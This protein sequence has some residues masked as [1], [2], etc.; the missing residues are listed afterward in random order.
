MTYVSALAIGRA[1]RFDGIDCPTDDAPWIVAGMASPDAL[2]GNDRRRGAGASPPVIAGFWD[3]SQSSTA[4]KF[5]F[6][7][8]H[9]RNIFR[10]FPGRLYAFPLLP[11]KSKLPSIDLTFV[12]P[13]PCPCR[14]MRAHEASAAV[15]GEFPWAQ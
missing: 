5:L 10:H 12:G 13:P 7:P 1:R 8:G 9:E 2:A 11:G 3:L 6:L 4:V 14:G 15:F